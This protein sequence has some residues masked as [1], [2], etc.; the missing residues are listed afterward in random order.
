MAPSWMFDRVLSM[1]LK[2]VSFIK[3]Y[4]AMLKV[5]NKITGN[6]WNLCYDLTYPLKQRQ[7][8]CWLWK[9]IYMLKLNFVF[10]E[11]QFF[12][13]STIPC[14]HSAWWEKSDI[15]DVIISKVTWHIYYW[16]RTKKE[17]KT[18]ILDP[19]SSKSPMIV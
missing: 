6:Q 5:D 18:R 19:D 10:L 4:K 8:F 17:F 13:H 9:S 14:F 2:C 12:I 1:P 11:L 15:N 7:V 3:V 16:E